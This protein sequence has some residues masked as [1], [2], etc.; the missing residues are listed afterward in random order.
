MAA[1][2]ENL[3]VGDLPAEIDQEKVRE[4]FSQYGTIKSLA[5]NKISDRGNRSAI[6]SF[7]SVEEATWVV[8]NLNGNI[9]Q[10]MTA[11]VTVSYKQQKGA[12]K[13]WQGGGYGG[14]GKGMDMGM[15]MGAP[16]GKGVDTPADSLFIGDLPADCDDE[17]LKSVFNNYGTVVSHHF[18]PPGTSGKK[19]CIVTF[20]SVEEATW[21]VQNL[22]GNIPQ[23]FTEPIVAR[24]KNRNN[25]KGKGGGW[26]AGWGGDA[27][28]GKGGDAG[29]GKGDKGGWGGWD[30]GWGA[31]D[32]GGWGAGDKGMG[33]GW[34]QGGGFG[35][36]NPAG[37]SVFVG[38]LPMG[39]DDATLQSVFGAYGNIKSHKI[40]PPGSTGSAAIITFSS[41]DEAKW[42][43][44][45]LNGNIP[46][47]LTGAVKVRFK[48]NKAGKGGPYGK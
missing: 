46:Q 8:N 27:S 14:Y 11:P 34:Q 3:F 25:N 43:V 26:D 12:G 37:D 39:I 42:L 9:P 48:D 36:G 10:G 38:D 18:T 32:K 6:I 15:G 4:V 41:V 19:A 21:I 30:A 35:G 33:K 1:P 23:G 13:G 7:G 2:S 5:L 17:R 40:L 47:G 31:G 24:Y 16:K 44:D 20:G 29:W 28:W 45:N 22:N